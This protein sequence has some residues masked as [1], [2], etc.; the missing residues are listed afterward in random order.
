MTLQKNLIEIPEEAKLV[1]NNVKSR[2]SC[3]V[4]K[5]EPLPKQHLEILLDAANFAP[6]PKNCQPWEFIVLTGEPLHQFHESVYQWLNEKEYTQPEKDKLKKLLPDGDYYTSL[7]A[8]LLKRQKKF[9]QNVS[10]QLEKF[11]VKLKDVYKNTFYCHYAPVVILVISESV[12]RDRHGLEIHQ[13]LAAAIQNILLVSHALG[14]G[15]CWIGDILRFGKKLN[16]HFD[17]DEM[18]EVVAA[19]AIGRPGISVTEVSERIK[20]EINTTETDLTMERVPKDSIEGKF[21]FLGF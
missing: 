17:I 20:E 4:F 19:I 8:E 7:P 12:K 10:G 16:L 3:R 11:G 13:A 9:I 5:D 15:S 1:I 6:S 21:K 18:K 14:Y 2:W